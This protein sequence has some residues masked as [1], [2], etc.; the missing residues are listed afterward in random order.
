MAK[1]AR[2]L[3]ETIPPHLISVA[4]RESAEADTAPAEKRGSVSVGGINSVD[5]IDTVS[6]LGFSQH[7]PSVSYCPAPKTQ[8]RLASWVG[9]WNRDDMKEVQ[10]QLRA[11]K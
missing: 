6:E 8:T 3:G 10:K 7:K 4:P 9:E 2:H 11:L 5:G 1:L